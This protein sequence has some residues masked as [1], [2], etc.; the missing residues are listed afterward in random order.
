M[1]DESEVQQNISTQAMHHGCTLMRNNSGCLPNQDGTP[2]RYGLGNISK[3][4]N[5]LIKSSDLI[6]ITQVKITP[7]MV[8]QTIGVFTAI[9]VKKEAWSPNKKLDIDEKAQKAFIDWV[10]FLGGI[11]GFAN[12]TESLK[13]IFK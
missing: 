13:G 8:G 11:A 1:K 12:S 10:R 2:V 9:E 4:R 6:G 5:K 7:E 3:K